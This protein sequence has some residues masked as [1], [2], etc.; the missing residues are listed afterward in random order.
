MGILSRGVTRG[1]GEYRADQ[2]FPHAG[3]PGLLL[4]LQKPE[5]LPQPCGGYS[6]PEAHR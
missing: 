4:P 6:V 5:R 2:I 1:Q 3:F